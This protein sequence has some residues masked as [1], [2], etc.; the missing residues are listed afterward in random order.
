[1][2][3]PLDPWYVTGLVELGGSF[4]YSRTDRNIVPYFGLK[5]GRDDH[6]LLEDVRA[7]FGGMGR[8]YAIRSRS[9]DARGDMLTSEST[10]APASPSRRSRYYRVTKIEELDLVVHHF[11]QYPLRGPKAPSYAAWRE[12][13][14]LKLD[15]YRKPDRERLEQLIG[16][17]SA[18]SRRR[19][20]R[21]KP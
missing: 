13:V 6:G 12:I 19:G 1:M 5:L 4:T 18:S 17:L 11:D 14:R 16:V 3:P 21:F 10:V 9:S 2:A 20:T 15:R 8:L 7:Y